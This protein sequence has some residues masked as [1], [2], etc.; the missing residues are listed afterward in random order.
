MFR[1]SVDL[2]GEDVTGTLFPEQYARA[3]MPTTVG[4]VLIPMILDPKPLERLIGN[5]THGQVPPCDQTLATL[6]SAGRGD[7]PDFPD[8]AL[9]SCC[10]HG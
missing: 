9:T 4:D 5:S 6:Q 10:L 8:H 2:H 7:V 1:T 3:L